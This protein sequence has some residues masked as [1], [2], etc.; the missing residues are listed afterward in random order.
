MKT[1]NNII[2]F[3]PIQ[4]QITLLKRISQFWFIRNYKTANHFIKSILT[5]L[6]TLHDHNT[7]KQYNVIVSMNESDWKFWQHVKEQKR[8]L[9]ETK[10]RIIRID[11]EINLQN[12]LLEYVSKRN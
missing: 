12:Q 11:E 10:E 7:T 2:P 6:E 5:S 3:I 1:P 4:K 8:M 9:Q